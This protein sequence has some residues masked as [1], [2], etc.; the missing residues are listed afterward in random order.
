MLGNT[1][2]HGPPYAAMDPFRTFSPQ[3]NLHFETTE[4]VT[5]TQFTSKNR[6]VNRSMQATGMWLCNSSSRNDSNQQNPQD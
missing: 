1:D 3:R 4:A 2:M 6:E 5:G